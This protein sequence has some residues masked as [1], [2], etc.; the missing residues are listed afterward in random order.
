V[1]FDLGPHL[2]DQAMVLF[3]EPEA[4]GA[5]VRIEREGA[6]VD[7]AFDVVL[8]YQKSRA[9]LRAG[10]LVSTQTPRFIIQ[11]TQGGYLK[12]GL[13]P[14]EGALKR[15]ERP[16]GEFWGYEAPERW[17]TLLR[18]QGDSFIAEKCATEAGDYRKYYANVRDAMLGT[19]Q[20]AVTPQQALRVMRALELAA[21]SSRS[22]RVLPW[23][24]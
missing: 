20:L 15:G 10:M 19:A 7:D 11:G 12:Y 8:H 6:S 4:I 16:S 23:N 14:Q 2:I 17:G 3:G 24:S 21:E 5:D 18:A 9:M 1:L 13:D 22:G